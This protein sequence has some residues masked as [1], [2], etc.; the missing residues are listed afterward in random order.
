MIQKHYESSTKDCPFPFPFTDEIKR[1][2]WFNF[3]VGINCVKLLGRVRNH[4]SHQVR[5]MTQKLL[6]TH[7]ES[8]CGND[9]D[10]EG[11]ALSI[12]QKLMNYTCLGYQDAVAYEAAKPILAHIAL[13][14]K[15][16][17][18]NRAYNKEGI[19]TQFACRHLNLKL[20]Q[21]LLTLSEE[22]YVSLCIRKEIVRDMYEKSPTAFSN[23][24][25]E[26][27][28]NKDNCAFDGTEE[29]LIL[30]AKDGFRT[31]EINLFIQMKKRLKEQRKQEK[32]AD[33]SDKVSK[34]IYSITPSP[35]SN[36]G[37]KGDFPHKKTILTSTLMTK[38]YVRL[39]IR[40]QCFRLFMLHPSSY[41][42]NV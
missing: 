10:S 35:Q 3:H 31:E 39:V 7:R 19:M 41:F 2:T 18:N 11:Q 17:K 33:R 4:Y 8:V 23:K 28:V 38:H 5:T 25:K 13:Y 21:D 12:S 32:E 1:Q 15:T 27:Y 20:V 42:L 26:A 6:K 24:L 36:S 40:I 34:F 14:R 9:D 16:S 37:K 30:H 29:D 22:A